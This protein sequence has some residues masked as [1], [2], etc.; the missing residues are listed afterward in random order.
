[1]AQSDKPRSR[2]YCVQMRSLLIL[3]PIFLLAAC[4][5]NK[6]ERDGGDLTRSEVEFLSSRMSEAVEKEFPLL[7]HKF[8][9]HYIDSLGQAIVARNPEMPPLPYEFRV[10]KSNEIFVFS[11]PG[12]IVYL[13]LGTLRAVELEGQLV[14]AIAHELAHQQLNHHLIEWRRKVNANRGQ[15]YLLDFSGDWRERFL[16]EAG[17][18]HIERGME[19]EADRLVPVLLYRGQYDPRLYISYL[20]LLKRLELNEKERV[21]SML[22]LHPPVANR[23]S[24]VKEE[25]VKLP[26]M[27]DPRVSSAAF[28]EL[29]IRLKDAEK[30][31]QDPP[32]AKTGKKH[33]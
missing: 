18:L 9:N 32:K 16:N 28:Q 2:I 24:W 6:V 19:E 17:A 27:R 29:K 5:G 7:K 4:S 31:K 25:L 26:P 11:L 33:G 1:M 22:S 12:G 10:L 23:I 15:R 8:V 30:Q 21:A 3:I 13:T 14:A 20:T